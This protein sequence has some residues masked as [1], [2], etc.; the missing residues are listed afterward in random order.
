MT[1]VTNNV[2]PVYLVAGGFW[3]VHRIGLCLSCVGS[4]MLSAIELLAVISSGI[5]GILLARR[6]RFDLVGVQTVAFIAAFGGGSL[7][8]VLLGRRPLFWIQHDHFAII[9]F[10]LA[11]IGSIVRHW[12]KWVERG[13]FLPDALGLGLFSIVGA[14][15]ALNEGTSL[16]VASLFGVITGTFGGV[17]GDVVC[18]QVPNLFRPTAP[19]YAT[20]SFLGCWVY[21]L[22]GVAGVAEPVALWSGIFAVVT[23]RLL[24]LRWDLRLPSTG[25]P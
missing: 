20:C 19:L 2:R 3:E 15:H 24:A 7:R 23:L 1:G 18:N 4:D 6:N 5:Y 25:E 12:P 8:D 13:L 9:I 17:I 10:V 21:L 14:S 22:L 11:L 16:F